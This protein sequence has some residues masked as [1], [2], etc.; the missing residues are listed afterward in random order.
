MA[1]EQTIFNT[2]GYI[3]N[4]ISLYSG[5]AD[6]ENKIEQ[7]A[8]E[9]QRKLQLGREIKQ[10]VLKLRVPIASLDKEEMESLEL[11]TNCGQ[12]EEIKAVEWRPWQKG[13]LEYVNNPTQRRVYR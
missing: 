12:V 4:R 1:W 2:C 6:L 13:M 8:H 9:Y 3:K 7:G 10:I 11:L 5:L